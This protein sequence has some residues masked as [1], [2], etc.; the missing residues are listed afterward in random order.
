MEVFSHF[1]FFYSHTNKSTW[2]GFNYIQ[3]KM[4]LKSFKIVIKAHLQHTGSV[5]QQPSL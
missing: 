2:N 3:S 5:A 1:Y 4:Y